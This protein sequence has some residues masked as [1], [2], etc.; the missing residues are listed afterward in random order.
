MWK[1]CQRQTKTGRSI[2]P[3]SEIPNAHTDV[4]E[5]QKTWAFR[6]SVPIMHI[7]RL[8]NKN[9][10]EDTSLGRDMRSNAASRWIHAKV[11]WL[12]TRVPA[13]ANGCSWRI[14]QKV[15]LSEPAWAR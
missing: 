9:T 4:Q 12:P 15:N 2:G 8:S 6:G 10:N 5:I 11:L 3:S 14:K 7:H 1:H 13:C